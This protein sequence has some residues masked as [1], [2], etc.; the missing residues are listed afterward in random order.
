MGSSPRSLRTSGGAPSCRAGLLD[1]DVG[2]QLVGVVG[3][4]RG[5][6]PHREEPGA[7]TQRRV[8]PCSPA[9]VEQQPIGVLEVEIRAYLIERMPGEAGREV[10]LPACRRTG[11]GVEEL[12][13]DG[14]ERR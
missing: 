8:N 12:N 5:L 13:V 6:L 9:I 4:T 7:L 1:L 11:D 3:G 2:A 10:E 14:E